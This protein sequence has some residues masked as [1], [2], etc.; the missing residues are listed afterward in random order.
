[1]N[2]IFKLAW[3]NIWRN[4]KR[5]LIT[6]LSVL[7]AVFLAIFTRSMQ[8]GMY[9][10][11]I[12]NVVNTYTG[13]IQIHKKGYWDDQTINNSFKPDKKLF[14]DVKSTKGVV[15]II[16]RLQTFSLMS[17]GKTTKGVLIQGVD[18][19][20][21]Q[22][23][24]NWKSRIMEGK[25]FGR[26]D[27]SVIISKGLADYFKKK[28]G[29]TLVFVG[30]GY[31]GMTAAGKYS[32]SGIIDMKNPKLNNSVVFFPLKLAQDY[33]SADG[34]ISQLVIAKDENTK[35]DKII[36]NLT[37]KL[38]VDKY[39]IIPWEKMI[40]ELKQAIAVDNMGG[41]IMIGIIYMIIAFGILGT[42]L[43]MTEERIYELGVMLAVGTKKLK[44]MMIL[45]LESI[46]LSLTG[47][48][49]GIILVLPIVHYYHN[50]PVLLSGTEGEAMKGFGFEPL[51]IL[52]TDWHISFAQA[53]IVLI[54]A[55][56]AALYPIY[57][58]SRLKPVDA[59]KEL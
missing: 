8:L 16:P 25:A 23:L 12:K 59:M 29:D 4:K 46:F 18:I 15:D 51:M 13:F 14:N 49:A 35:T 39:E 31:H 2:L 42:V 54:V 38:D 27:R 1:M 40:P 20:K 32:I 41:I 26:D 9:G 47:V 22:I 45:T 43:M 10:N 55:L 30:Q 57:K 28:P 24:T 11:M 56:F 33:C 6:I 34:M 7:V 53:M 44:L 19:E 58:I 3:R 36:K 21:E 48:L 5:S 52:S 50:N 37:K 17:S